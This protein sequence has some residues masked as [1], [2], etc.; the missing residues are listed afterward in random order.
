MQDKIQEVVDKV[1]RAQ[2]PPQRVA[3]RTMPKKAKA[4][5]RDA[6]TKAKQAQQARDEERMMK[7]LRKINGKD[8]KKRKAKNRNFK[9]Q[10]V[11]H[12]K[13]RRALRESN[14]ELWALELRRTA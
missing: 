13:Q 8:E 14:P 9:P 11:Q 4:D 3:P 2:V 10:H 5:K 7:A 6:L 12:P 1:A